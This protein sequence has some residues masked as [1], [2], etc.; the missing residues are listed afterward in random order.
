MVQRL[1]IYCSYTV[2]MII[3]LLLY[4]RFH[5]DLKPKYHNIKF[6]LIDIKCYCIVLPEQSIIH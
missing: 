2:E 4:A 3:I 6:L 1:V 5:S